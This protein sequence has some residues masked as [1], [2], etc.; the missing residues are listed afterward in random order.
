MQSKWNSIT[1]QL[2]QMFEIMGGATIVTGG[3]NVPPNT[4]E[5]GGLGLQK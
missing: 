4:H 1:A 2:Q 5:C 3:D